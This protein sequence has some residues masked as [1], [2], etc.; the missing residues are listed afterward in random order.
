MRLPVNHSS[1]IDI[2]GVM[3]DI[4]SGPREMTT[5]AGA[6]PSYI[7]YRIRCVLP[8]TI[9]PNQLQLGINPPLSGQGP[10]RSL[11]VH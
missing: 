4:S 1:S 9:V 7:R 5:F 11:V 6:C 3:A 2:S 10:P 8:V